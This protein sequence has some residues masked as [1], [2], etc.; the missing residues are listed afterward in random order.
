MT[1]YLLLVLLLL[2]LAGVLMLLTRQDPTAPEA[3]KRFQEVLETPQ[4]ETWLNQRK[5]RRARSISARFKRFLEGVPGTDMQEIE[6]LLRRAALAEDRYR[7]AIYTAL[8]A[9]PLAGGVLGMFAAI[10]GDQ[11]VMA[12]TMVGF[13]VGYILPRSTLRILAEQIGRA[14]V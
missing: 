5:W 13:V 2:A 1:L 3:E 7:A 6:V 11:P 10:R 14:H 4:D 9:L 8:W 12:F